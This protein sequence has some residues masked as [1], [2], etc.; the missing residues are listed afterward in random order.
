MPPRALAQGTKWGEREPNP[1][2]IVSV[3]FVRLKCKQWLGKVIVS[4]EYRVPSF[5]ETRGS[6][7]VEP[8]RSARGI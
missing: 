3:D 7:T 4:V 5:L 6:E 8:P 1:P 2:D